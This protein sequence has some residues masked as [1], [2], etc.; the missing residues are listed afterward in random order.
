MRERSDEA[1]STAAADEKSGGREHHRCPRTR[2]EMF[3]CCSGSDSGNDSRLPSERDE[4]HDRI[5]AAVCKRLGEASGEKWLHVV[6]RDA[7]VRVFRPEWLELGSK[8]TQVPVGL[9]TDTQESTYASLHF[10]PV[11]EPNETDAETRF[12]YALRLKVPDPAFSEMN[13]RVPAAIRA[14][15]NSVPDDGQYTLQI[16]TSGT[17]PAI[18]DDGE[19][20]DDVSKWYVRRMAPYVRAIDRVIRP[21]LVFR[22]APNSAA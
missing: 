4:H 2:R 8:H 5:G 14:V 13:A 10:R 9:S 11:A 19:I 7:G 6:R 21:N 1:G 15:N 18:R 3:R 16:K 20:P 17:L 22:S 12:R